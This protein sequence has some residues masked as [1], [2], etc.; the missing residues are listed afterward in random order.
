MSYTVVIVKQ[1][2]P[3]NDDA[4]WQFMQELADRPCQEP[5]PH[6]YHKLI[7]RLTAV[8]PCICELEDSDGAW[9]DGPLRNNVGP[10]MTLLG[11]NVDRVSEVMPFVVKTANDLGLVVFDEQEG[12]IYRP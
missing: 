1:P 3:D 12:H 9:S 5:V 4:A 10:A 11:L 2:I 6:V 7:D 8:Y